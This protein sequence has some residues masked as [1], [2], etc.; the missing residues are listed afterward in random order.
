LNVHFSAGSERFASVRLDPLE[1]LF[2]IQAS[3]FIPLLILS[4]CFA[5]GQTPAAQSTTGADSDKRSQPQPA[6]VA[7]TWQV[8]WTVRG[9]TEPG[10]LHLQQDGAKLTGTFQDLHGLS[11]LAGTVD[12]K[13]I[14]FDVHFAGSHPFTI[15]F[16]GTVDS[17]DIQ[18]TSE[19]VGLV[20]GGAYL[21]H[22]GEVV[23]PEHPWTAK[24][25]ASPPPQTGET[26]SNP[27]FRN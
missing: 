2:V 7:G 16:V 19:A 21:G 24:R 18:G 20:G 5:A 10:T 14:S 23:H 9:G 4:C 8:S 22:A 3:R 1:E 13:R 11:S 12:A 17:S 15:R 26:G 27:P 6:D 25:L